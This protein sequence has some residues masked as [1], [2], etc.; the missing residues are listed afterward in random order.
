MNAFTLLIYVMCILLIT[1]VF[2]CVSFALSLLCYSIPVCYVLTGL[3]LALK[4][5]LLWQ[6]WFV[7]VAYYVVC[8]QPN[9]NS[10]DDSHA[11]LSTSPTACPTCRHKPPC[12][13]QRPRGGILHL[14]QR[15]MGGGLR[16]RLPAD[17]LSL[18][19]P[20]VSHPSLLRFLL[21]LLVVFISKTIF[22]WGIF[23]TVFF[24]QIKY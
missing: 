20:C 3:F 4:E 23:R 17:I 10:L 7:W 15:V 14:G 9:R 12:T 24:L 1:K 11:V 16:R 6:I 13:H 2:C 8:C 19:R 22:F 18:V 5:T 21:F